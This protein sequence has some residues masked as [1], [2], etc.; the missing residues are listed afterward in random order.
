MTNGERADR[1]F[2]DAER[3]AAE[4]LRAADDAAWN[5]VVRRAQEVVEL[6]IKALLTQMTVDYPKTHDPAPAFVEALRR[7]GVEWDPTFLAHLL[8][9]SARLERLRSPAFY[10]EITIPEAEARELAAGASEVLAAGRTLLAR[11]RQA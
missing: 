6:V 2:A 7:R 1:F 8:E 10:Q 9:L 4:V 11:L 3:I 5:L